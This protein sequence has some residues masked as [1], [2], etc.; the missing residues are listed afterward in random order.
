MQI[1]TLW[2]QIRQ[3]RLQEELVR[4]DNYN[5]LKKIDDL[6]QEMS[7]QEE[8]L[9]FFD[10]EDKIDLQIERVSKG[11]TEEKK[12]SKRE[13]ILA[14]INYVPPEVDAKRN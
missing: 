6:M 11:K 5:R 10:N 12:L 8:K 7:D 13:K 14:D 2:E 1:Y 4:V 3:T 9:W